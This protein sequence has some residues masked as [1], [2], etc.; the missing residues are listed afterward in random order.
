MAVYDLSILERKDF[1]GT[2]KRFDRS[3]RYDQVNNGTEA[4]IKK[5]LKE[6]NIE[7][8]Y[9]ESCGVSSLCCGQEAINVLRQEHYFKFPSGKFASYDDAVMSHVNT[10]EGYESDPDRFDNRYAR[11]YPKIVENLFPECKSEYLKHKTFFNAVEE[12][13]KG[14]AVQILLEAGHWICLI[15]YLR[16]DNELVYHD[17]WGSR[18]GLKNKGLFERI[19]LVEYTESVMDFIIT[20]EKVVA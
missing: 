10:F 4:I 8:G 20:Y 5:I 18:P 13:K 9:L 1:V 15:G 11:T 6:N 2:E 14:K 16:D 12:I 19:G 7:K 3:I 17:S